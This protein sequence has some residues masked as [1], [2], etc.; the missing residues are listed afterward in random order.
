MRDTRTRRGP[1]RVALAATAA[2]LAFALVGTGVAFAAGAGHDGY[3]TDADLTGTADSAPAQNKTLPNAGQ[4]DYQ[5]NSLAAFCHFGPNTFANIEWGENYGNGNKEAYEYINDG[6]K[7]FDADNYVKM[8]KEAGFQRLVFTVKHHDGFCLYQSELTDYDMQQVTAY[9][10]GKGDLLEDL[11][12]ACTK[13]D[14]D[15]GLYLSPWDIHDPSYGYHSEGEADEIGTTGSSTN[16]DINY[17]YFY[18]GQLEEI[19]SNPKYGNNGK[20]VEVWMDGA[21][22]GDNDPTSPD[23]QVYTYDMWAETIHEYEGE[24]CLIFQC[25]TNTG[26]RW[27]GNESGTSV[28]TQTD[29][30]WSPVKIIDTG[31]KYDPRTL[32]GVQVG[33]ADGDLWTVPEV[34]A[35]ITSGWFWGTGGKSTPKSLQELSA[36]YFNSIG[37]GATFLLNV[38]LN[39]SGT[40][41]DAI[42]ARVEEFAS[43]INNSFDDNLAEGATAYATSAYASDPEYGPGKV[44]DGDQDSFWCANANDGQSLIIELDGKQTFDIVSIEEAIQNGQRISSF[45]VSYRDS[46]GNWQEFGS[47]ATIGSK[48]LVRSTPV[49]SDAIKIEVET[50]DQSASV[51]QLAQ[52][53]EVGVYEASP[54]FEVPTPIPVGFEGIDNLEMNDSGT[55]WTN[56]SISSCYEGTSQWS[57]NNRSTLTFTF[58]GT[59]FCIIGTADPGHGTMG[60]QIDGGDVIQVKTNEVSARDVSALLYSSPALENDEHTVVISV[61]SGAVGIDAAAYLPGGT[62]MVQFDTATATMNEDSTLTLT[63]TRVGDLDE[64]LT[65]YVSPE[66]GT[67]TQGHFDTESQT[68]TFAPGE[69]TK[70]ATVSSKRVVGGAQSGG[71]ADGDRSFFATLSLSSDDAIIGPNDVVTIM[72]NDLDVDLQE[73]LDASGNLDVSNCS[74]ETA[75]AYLDALEAAYN[76]LKNEAI[77]GTELEAR[78]EALET[79][80][81]GLASTT[82]YTE[83]TPF[84]FP[85][86]SRAAVMEA[87]YGILKNDPNYDGKWPASVNTDDSLGITYVGALK[88]KDSL[89]IPIKVDKDGSYNVVLTYTSGSNSNS[90]EWSSKD[91]LIENGSV[92]AGAADEAKNLHTKEFT[93]TATNAGTDTL[94]IHAPEGQ[95][96][97]RM[98][99]FT[100]T[101]AGDATTYD[102]TTEV[103]G[104]G[105]VDPTEATVEAGG[106]Q[107][108]SATPAEGHKVGTVTANGDAVKV[109]GNRFTLVNVSENTEV[110]VTFI[111]DPD[112]TFTVTPEVGEGGSVTP[113]TVDVKR[114]ESQEFTVTPNPGYDVDEVLV[115]GKAVPVTDGTFTVTNLQPDTTIKVSFKAVDKTALST[116]IGECAALSQ[117]DYTADSWSAFAAALQD[118]REVFNDAASTQADVD[119]ALAALEAAKAALKPAGSTTDPGTNPDQTPGGG[120]DPDDQTPGDTTKPGGSST[121]GTTTGSSTSGGSGSGSLAKTADPTSMVAVLA[122]ALAGAGALVAYRKRR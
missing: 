15:M 82:Q 55:S 94:V 39:T 59:Q 85:T 68:I 16:P 32:G 112:Y 91:G 12:T 38:P 23:A 83:D 62:T 37:H 120:T 66:P 54:A 70:T 17:N 80:A 119:D 50:Y 88:T 13:Y 53:S 106:A 63:L 31:I 108:F 74:T 93:F 27:I 11:S 76:A 104:N 96:C 65:V 4:L 36:M 117:D 86:S 115:N 57:S 42:K 14:M 77:S 19:L 99:K 56:E 30:L 51:Q 64:E 24:D 78:I 71:S 29:E 52:I 102:V 114:G 8:L 95:E 2:A 21:K 41:D 69:S 116:T 34:D 40:V 45:R 46:D 35:K 67:A 84:V 61:V 81:A 10:D 118:A 121:G 90:L 60:V 58:T 22:G 3:V 97:P 113:D 109:E 110:A 26:V 28:S 43:S 105:T 48:R 33:Y 18:N 72:I 101:Y 111:E 5:R 47:G 75:A 73:A 6:W 20:F 9:K 98:D 25:E 49:R 122:T 89:E 1:L 100:I 107:S 79:A 44:L 103:T 87:E 7:G 92:V